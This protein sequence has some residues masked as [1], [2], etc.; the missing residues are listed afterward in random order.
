MQSLVGLDINGN[1]SQNVLENILLGKV[2]C[3]SVVVKRAYLCPNNFWSTKKHSKL[4]A[5]NEPRVFRYL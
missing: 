5:D 3:K 1:V 2:Q 4:L